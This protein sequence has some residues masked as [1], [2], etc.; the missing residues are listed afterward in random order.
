VILFVSIDL[1]NVPRSLAPPLG[2]RLMFKL[3]VGNS[4]G[5]SLVG[6]QRAATD[7]GN[8]AMLPN[9]IFTFTVTSSWQS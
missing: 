4:V 9:P 5:S 6:Q 7:H 3:S 1:S 8:V 2:E